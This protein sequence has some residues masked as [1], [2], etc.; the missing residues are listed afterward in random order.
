MDVQL[1]TT[2]NGIKSSLYNKK[3]MN[4]YLYVPSRSAYLSGGLKGL[5]TGMTKLIFTLTTENLDNAQSLHELYLRLSSCGYTHQMLAPLFEK[6][7]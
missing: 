4:L 6:A 3:A 2:P 1:T 5:I 7:L